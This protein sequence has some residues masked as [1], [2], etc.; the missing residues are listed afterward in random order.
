M[1]FSIEWTV[2]GSSNAPKHNTRLMK[3]HIKL[4]FYRFLFFF[5]MW[6]PVQKSPSRCWVL[7]ATARALL[8]GSYVVCMAAYWPNL[9]EPTSKTI[10]WSLD[11]SVT[12][13][14]FVFALLLKEAITR[15][16]HLHQLSLI[17]LICTDE[18]NGL[19]YISWLLNGINDRL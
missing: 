17:P 10:L 14:A 6:V 3:T 11:I 9:I 16:T 13:L 2:T 18:A 7:W 15:G 8:G 5:F 12:V 19:T 1:A 4:H